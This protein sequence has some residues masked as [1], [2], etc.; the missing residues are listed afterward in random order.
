MAK[1]ELSEEEMLSAVDLAYEA[2]PM[3]E[4]LEIDRLTAQVWQKLSMM[5]T[6]HKLSERSIRLLIAC[7]AIF[8][9]NNGKSWTEL[10]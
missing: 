2:L 5:R 3:D 9:N 1:L 6:L 4:R 8:Q 10:M 7:T